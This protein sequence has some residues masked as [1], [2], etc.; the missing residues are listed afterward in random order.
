MPIL[1]EQTDSD[2]QPQ[3]K[4]SAVISGDC[5]TYHLSVMW[6]KY[7]KFMYDLRR[8]NQQTLTILTNQIMIHRNGS[9]IPSETLAFKSYPALEVDTPHK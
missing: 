7:V 1:K 2:H 3:K 9:Q 8:T 6:L 5:Y 4:T